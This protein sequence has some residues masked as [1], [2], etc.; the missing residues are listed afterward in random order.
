MAHNIGKP[1]KFPQWT[2]TFFDISP[3]FEIFVMKSMQ[4]PEKKSEKFKLFFSRI[5]GTSWNRAKTIFRWSGGVFFFEKFKL[6]FFV[7]FWHLLK[8]CKKHFPMVRGDLFFEKL[9]LFFSRIVDTIN[10]HENP[11]RT[12]PPEIQD[13][14]DHAQMIERKILCRIALT[15]A[16]YDQ[17]RP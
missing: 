5:C 16:L 12:T 7:K 10:K 6:V 17:I 9:K 8:S 4:S 1:F 13:P 3:I 11:P 14:W 2:R 15:R